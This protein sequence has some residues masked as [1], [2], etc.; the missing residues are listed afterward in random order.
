MNENQSAPEQ[1]TLFDLPPYAVLKCVAGFYIGMFDD[2]PEDGPVKR[3]S[4]RY[5]PSRTE[6]DSALDSGDWVPFPYLL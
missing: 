6:A 1:L 4:T 3:V 2:D 5:W